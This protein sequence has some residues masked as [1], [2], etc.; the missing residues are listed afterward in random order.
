M[1]ET[2]QTVAGTRTRPPEA[3][4]EAGPVFVDA[5]GQRRR[6]L[7][8]GGIAIGAALTAYVIALALSFLGGPLPPNALLPLPGVPAGAPSQGQDTSA[9]PGATTSSGTAATARAA[10]TSQAAASPQPGATTRTTGSASAP[11]PM[12]SPSP[13]ATVRKPT[14]PPGQVSKSPSHTR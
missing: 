11:A 3:Q 13:S 9:A 10:G 12:P 5:S 7:R 4:P 14:T 2:T 1:R 8:K 6:R